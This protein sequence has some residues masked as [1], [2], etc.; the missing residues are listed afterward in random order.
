M[1]KKVLL[2]CFAILILFVA[3]RFWPKPA[4][5]P[6][7]PPTAVVQT[8]SGPLRG[9]SQDGLN[10]YL[11]IPYAEPPTGGRRFMP[12]VPR[13]PWKNTL[14]AFAFGSFC[15]QVYDPVVIEDRKE[16][17]NNEDCL[18]LN[19]WAP[20][21]G[22]SKRA[23]MVYLHGGGF[24][25][26]SSKESLYHGDALA[27]QGDVIVVSLNYRLAFL[28]FFDFSVLGGSGYAGSADLGIQDQLLALRW[29]KDNI[30]AF[31]GD[32]ENIT[33]F[34]ESAGAGSVKALLGVDRPQ[35]YFRRAI[36]MSGSPLHSAVNSQAIADLVK[37]GAGIPWA[38]VW[39]IM[40]TRAL[41]YIQEK[42][43]AEVGS[44]LSDL[45]FAPT[46]GS[47][48]V[49]QRNPVE[50][51]A[52][53]ATQ[54]IDLMIGTMA[55]EMTYWS[56]YDTA[57]SHIC[58]QTLD[59]NLFT[60]VDSSIAPKIQAL[61][62]LYAANPQRAGQPEGRILLHMEDDYAFRVD[63]L[64]LAS[65]QSKLAPTYVYR[66]DYPVNLPDQPCQ[67]DHSPHGSELPFVFGKIDDPTGFN[68]IGKPRDAQDSTVRQKLMD[69]MISAWTNFA[70]TGDPN[71]GS[72]PQWPEFDAAAQPTMIFGTDTHLEN[73]PFKAEY[74]AMSA[75][76]Q[77]FSVF[78]ALK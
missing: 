43:L 10:V 58:E 5:V 42:T 62:D 30:A 7:G 41:M 13:Q 21:S 29:V 65:Q 55:D 37:K 16:D 36:V 38:W 14:D 40:P 77:T 66:M 22:T 6:G 72:V 39:K 28:G 8:Q 57:D 63:S 67:K 69:Q 52:Q 48:Y 60:L 26:G 70:K 35:D 2:A 56:F 31:G 24:F 78:D 73:A 61:Y 25:E 20:S 34:G 18:T 33:A 50:A 3:W 23:V 59:E 74:E 76:M 32:P 75:F 9:Y 17:L 49:I 15:P 46:Y 45:L 12:P 27:K 19:I 44:P 71:G 11:G 1:R 47:G 64:D 54:G 53:G 51:A 68:F 4:P